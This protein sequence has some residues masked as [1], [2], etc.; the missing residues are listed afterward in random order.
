MVVKNPPAN[1]GGTRDMGSVLGSGRSPLVGNGNFLQYS[2]LENSLD[3]EAWQATAHEVTESDMTEP[4]C[5]HTHTHTHT[6]TQAW[7]KRVGRGS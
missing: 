5:T 1:A 2:C 7:L 4:V 6:H 3:R